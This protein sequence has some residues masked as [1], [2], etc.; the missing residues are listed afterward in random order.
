M[1]LY[2]SDIFPTK[3]DRSKSEFR[4][5]VQNINTTYAMQ[6]LKKEK[7]RI[8]QIL[9]NIRSVHSY[10]I[11]PQKN[12]TPLKNLL[13][14]VDE[15]TPEKLSRPKN[16]MYWKLLM[17][18]RETNKPF[19]EEWRIKQKQELAEF[20][21]KII[22]DRE[23]EKE[24]LRQLYYVKAEN[25]NLNYTNTYYSHLQFMRQQ[26]IRKQEEYRQG[27]DM[28][29]KQKTN[30]SFNTYELKKERDNYFDDILGEYKD[31]GLVPG[32]RNVLS[33]G[34]RPTCR[35]GRFLNETN[36]IQYS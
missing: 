20:N 25:E 11:S 29:L 19:I 13:K 28:Q 8:D 4:S 7:S 2:K 21:K 26:K 15:I 9:N 3:K 23:L 34:S 31:V 32:I 18:L 22:K 14:K 6:D 36:F 17:K 33:I 12:V 24:K 16:N 30:K 1:N 5:R 35:P 10:P 27:L